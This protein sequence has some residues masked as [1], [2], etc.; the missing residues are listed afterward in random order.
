MLSKK[1]KLLLLFSKLQEL[2]RKTILLFRCLRGARNNFIAYFEA[3][4]IKI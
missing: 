1:I 3:L 2:S 4:Q